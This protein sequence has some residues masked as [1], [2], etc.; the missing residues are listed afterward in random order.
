MGVSEGRFSTSQ[1]WV[2]GREMER[3]E[4]RGRFSHDI[5]GVRDGAGRTLHKWNSLVFRLTSK[6]LVSQMSSFTSFANRPTLVG[7]LSAP[8]LRLDSCG[9]PA[10]ASL[11][12]NRHCSCWAET[13]RLTSD[14]DVKEETAS[15]FDAVELKL[16]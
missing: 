9:P 5:E 1:D 7:P 13:H 2:E 12:N 10:P 8:R 3:E 16:I 6:T 15:Q 4:K 11:D 14:G